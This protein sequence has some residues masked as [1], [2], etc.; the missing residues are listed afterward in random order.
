MPGLGSNRPD[1]SMSLNCLN[2]Q[3]VTGFK[4]MPATSYFFLMDV[5]RVPDY[6]PS[7][8]YRIPLET[9]TGHFKTALTRFGEFGWEYLHLDYDRWL[10]VPDGVEIFRFE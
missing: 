6:T 1:L 2:V 3:R 4:T 5:T 7:A 9:G 10:P 8:T